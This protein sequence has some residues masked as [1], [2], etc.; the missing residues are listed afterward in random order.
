MSGCGALMRDRNGSSILS[1]M[2]RPGMVIA[3]ASAWS[4][5]TNRSPS[6][7]RMNMI[8]HQAPAANVR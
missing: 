2:T 7:A 3:V 1:V 4:S 6:S 5:V 8:K